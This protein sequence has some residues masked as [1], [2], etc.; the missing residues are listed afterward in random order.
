MRTWIAALLLALLA[1]APLVAV[2]PAAARLE[3]EIRHELL[4]LPAY[5]LFDHVAFRLEGTTVVLTGEVT[6][7]TLKEDAE[8][9]VRRIAGVEHVRN[10]IRVLPGS[11]VDEQIRI[12]AYRAI[13]ST[14]TLNRYATQAILP[15]HILVENGR[16][17]L[18][19]AVANE[20][21]RNLAY[22]KALEVPG[23]FSV[24]NR[25]V[26]EQN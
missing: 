6:K 21:D 14:P 4:L 16:I 22:T 3:R 11:P 18:I 12:A 10:E 13:Y 17:T 1:V 15:I 9:M 5:T 19:G 20:A 24:T 23:V 26:V 25:L 7:S 8:R 2:E